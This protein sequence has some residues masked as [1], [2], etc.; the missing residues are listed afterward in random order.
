M[1]IFYCLR[2]ETPLTGRARSPYL[3]PPGTGWPGYTPRHWVPV[4]SPPT[5]R[6]ATVEV[7]EPAST[8]R[9]LRKLVLVIYI[10]ILG[11]DRVEKS[12]FYCCVRVC[13]HVIAT[14]PLP[15]KGCLYWLYDVRKSNVNVW[16]R[17]SHSCDC[18]ECVFRKLLL[19]TSVK[20]HRSFGP[21]SCRLILLVLCLAYS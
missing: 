16:D 17:G 19:R 15:N 2:F 21:F 14:G 5:A 9:L 10:Y 6:R 13:D 12:A 8:P 4:P 18:E 7:F 3:Y 1:T 11:T 20:V